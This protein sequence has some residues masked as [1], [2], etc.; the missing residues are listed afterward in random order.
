VLFLGTVRDGGGFIYKGVRL[1]KGKKPFTIL[2]IRTMVSDAE[3]RIGATLYDD[4]PSFLLWYGSF[5]R[6]TRLDEL[7]Q[8]INILRGDMSFIGPRPIRPA[9]YENSLQD[10]INYDNRFITRPGLTGYAQFLTPYGTCKRIRAKVDNHFTKGQTSSVSDIGLILWTIGRC[11]YTSAA[12]IVTLSYQRTRMFFKGVGRKN[13]RMQ[14]RRKPQN[15]KGLVLECH[16]S[17]SVCSVVDINGEALLL[18]SPHDQPIPSKADMLMYIDV[19]RKKRR[20]TKR[21]KGSVSIVTQR[22]GKNGLDHPLTYYV[23]M[24]TPRSAYHRYLIDKYI[25]KNTMAGV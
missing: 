9:L 13:A 23:A 24:Y 4:N 15:V 6:Q 22:V 5:L 7:P 20:R 10:I 19:V 8:L 21:I 2:K 25:L 17:S 3:K 18:S 14:K 11:A 1:G 16:G 12:E